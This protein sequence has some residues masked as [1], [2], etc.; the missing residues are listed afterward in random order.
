MIK[1]VWDSIAMVPAPIL[2]QRATI[3]QQKKGEE[4]R[5]DTLAHII[6]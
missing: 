4:A 6:H 3:V 1:V 5:A 2:S